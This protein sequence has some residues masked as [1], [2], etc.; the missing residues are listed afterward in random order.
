MSR[1]D[2]LEH[3]PAGHGYHQVTRWLHAGLVLGVIFQLVC[4]ALMAHPDHQDGEQLAPVLSHVAGSEMGSMDHEDSQQGRMLM[5]AH[6]TGGLVV[7]IM[8][9]ANL[10]WA[11]MRRGKPR[12]RQFSVLISKQHWQEALSIA[13]SMPRMLLGRLPLPEPG[14]SLSLVF[15]MLGM[16]V[17]SAMAVTGSMIWGLWSG[18]GNHVPAQAEMLMEAHAAFAVLLFL[19][20]TG[21]VSMALMHA[22]AGDPVFSRI[23]P[24]GKN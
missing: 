19:Y 2:G 18:S 1:I 7:A 21:H 22:H 13:R 23:M 9:L 16:L 5:Q 15:E 24:L 20:L 10:I 11:L 4:A 12:K 17:M 14:N 6:R 8:V 3:S